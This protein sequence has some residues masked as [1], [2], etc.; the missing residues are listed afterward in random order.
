MKLVRYLVVIFGFLIR[1]MIVLIIYLCIKD[2]LIRNWLERKYLVNSWFLNDFCS[3]YKWLCLWY[4]NII[5][6]LINGIVV[7]V[8][9]YRLKVFIGFFFLVLMNSIVVNIIVY[10]L[11]IFFYELFKNVW[12]L[13]D[14]K[15][16]FINN[17]LIW[18]GEW[19]EL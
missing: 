16:Y 14:I 13:Y 15:F 3:W 9:V 11:V 5:I 1:N 7:N 6:V 2:F 12:I 18:V 8:N 17:I 4:L 10:R 19:M